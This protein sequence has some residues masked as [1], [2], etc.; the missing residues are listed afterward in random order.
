M[1]SPA[2]RLNE[3]KFKGRTQDVARQRRTEETV[4]LRKQ[5][6][7]EAVRSYPAATRV[8]LSLSLCVSVCV[9][10]SVCLCVSVCVCLCAF[11]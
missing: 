6:R 3:F 10:L 2:S 1:A 7:E 8:S 5:K 4:Q 9:S 11:V